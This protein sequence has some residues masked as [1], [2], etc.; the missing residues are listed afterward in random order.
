MPSTASLQILLPAR[1][2]RRLLE[3]LTLLLPILPVA[4]LYFFQDPNL[5]FH[6][7]NFHEFAIALALL[8]GLFISYVSWR[9]YAHSGEV[10]V[11]WLT[12]GFIGFTV[13]Y[14]LHGLFTPVA[15]HN[16]WL[17]LLYG[18]ASRLLMS[19]CMAIA[20]IK[21]G[22]EPDAPEVR[23][24]FSYWI[25]W[26]AL[27]L[28][29]NVAV[30]ILAYSSLAGERWVRASQEF[31]SIALC[32]TSFL[33]IM[34]K[35]GRL[36]LMLYY[37][38]ALVWL[39]VSALAFMLSLPWNHLWWL[40]HGIF[41]GGFSIL[42]YG[43]L[44]SY[45][46]T[47]SFDRVFNQTEMFEDLAETNARL[48]EVKDHLDQT[49]RRLEA[50]AQACEIAR[51][52]FDTLFNL[53]PDGI[54]AAE[55]G[56]SIAQANVRAEQMFGYP[57]GGLVGVNVDALIPEELREKHARNRGLYEYSPS[58]R[59]MGKLDASLSC[60]HREGHRFFAAISISGMILDGR[61]CVMAFVRDLTHLADYDAQRHSSELASI[62][63]GQ[64]LDKVVSEF[65]A[66]VFQFKRK[67]DGS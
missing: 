24:N 54:I 47:Q 14:S 43:V 64:L 65:P 3:L 49:N 52:Q 46:T 44:R 56:G 17:F 59:P 51:R 57:P 9:C 22:S 5:I 61:Q 27:F 20:L 34:R 32:L 30:A 45:L 53:S 12:V 38:H 21:S 28:V 4:Y 60:L 67:R 40:A 33:I 63:N 58:T 36:P 39:A 31:T 29:I 23:E 35:S 41:A 16:I 15:E 18:S 7:H 48:N 1:L 10:F 25:A 2:V 42:G 8:E 66:L 13:V 62:T 26:F 50:Q 11:K 37:A 6:S 55:A 19:V